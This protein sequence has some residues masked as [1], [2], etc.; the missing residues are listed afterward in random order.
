MASAAYSKFFIEFSAYL[1]ANF[2]RPGLEEKEQIRNGPL[3][4][5][6]LDSLARLIIK[7]QTGDNCAAVALVNNEWYFTAN[8]YDKVKENLKCI[9][10]ALK[11]NIKFNQGEVVRT[12]NA[13]KYLIK[14]Y[15]KGLNKPLIKKR[16]KKD[17]R[18]FL[19]ALKTNE[20]FTST[21][22]KNLF[23]KNHR[24]SYK[25]SWHLH[26]EMRLLLRMEKACP[27]TNQAI[28]TIGISKL[29][30]KLCA[31]GV[32]AFKKRYKHLTINLRGRHGNFYYGWVP[33]KLLLDK[34]LENFIGKKA[35]L[36]YSRASFEAQESIRETLLNLEDHRSKLQVFFTSQRGGVNLNS[37]S[38]EPQN[39]ESETISEEVSELSIESSMYPEDSSS[40]EEN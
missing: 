40:E 21:E 24:H 2:G 28:V 39:T 13:R 34:C 27:Q 9:L 33:P 17:V 12:R 7:D 6:R 31:S 18:K 16:L 10:K 32:A 5:R 25:N 26:A 38:I 15:L 1:N 19:S 23:S 3:K 30:C 36:I 22:I 37:D 11:K 8:N 29:C 35:H 20:V 14:N 4:I